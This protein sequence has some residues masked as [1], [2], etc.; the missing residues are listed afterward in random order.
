MYQYDVKVRGTLYLWGS[1]GISQNMAFPKPL[2]LHIRNDNFGETITFGTESVDGTRITVG[3]LDAGE[4]ASVLVQSIRG[5]F[6]TCA[7]DSSV[8]CAI[9][10]FS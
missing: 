7:L 9:E 10:M 1:A 6:A 3:T 8:N 2:L 4:C 5:V